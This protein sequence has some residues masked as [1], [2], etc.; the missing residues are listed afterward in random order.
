MVLTDSVYCLEG[1]HCAWSIAL[2]TSRSVSTVGTGTPFT[3]LCHVV[4]M[5]VAALVSVPV[6]AFVRSLRAMHNLL[7]RQCVDHVDQC[8]WPLLWA[9]T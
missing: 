4:L 8:G 6:L 7:F 9:L 1:L 2:P 5:V 3:G